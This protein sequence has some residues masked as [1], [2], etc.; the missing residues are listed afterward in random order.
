[1]IALEDATAAALFSPT[2]PIYIQPASVDVNDSNVTLVTAPICSPVPT[3]E[4]VPLGPPVM[5][6]QTAAQSVAVTVKEA[7]SV[8]SASRVRMKTLQLVVPARLAAVVKPVMVQV[9]VV[10][11]VETAKTI[12]SPATVPVGLLTTGLVPVP[13]VAVRTES[14][15][16]A[17]SALVRSW[18]TAAA[19]ATTEPAPAS[20]SVALVYV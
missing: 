18:L 13:V 3:T 16:T 10:L 2:A 14:P 6:W 1:V 20:G 17:S 7:P 4:I 11:C 19:G 5:T 12:R 8:P 15:V 9:A